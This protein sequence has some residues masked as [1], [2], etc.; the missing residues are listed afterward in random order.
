MYRRKDTLPWD[1]LGAALLSALALALTMQPPELVKFS[2]PLGIILVLFL[3]GYAVALAMFPRAGDLSAKERL[4]LSLGLCIAI[5]VLVAIGLSIMGGVEPVSLAQSLSAISLIT[6]AI[7]YVRRASLPRG[8]RFVPSYRRDLWPIGRRQTMGIQRNAGAILLALAVVIVLSAFAYT[9]TTNITTTITATPNRADDNGFT[10]FYV[11][12]E[13]SP[14]SVEAGSR[15]AL[16]VGIINRE[17]HAVDYTLRLALAHTLKDSILSEKNIELDHNETWEKPVS[18]IVSDPGDMQRL[19]LLLYKGSDFSKPYQEKHIWINVSGSASQS[20]L[21]DIS[22]SAAKPKDL[23]ESDLKDDGGSLSEDGLKASRND[24]STGGEAASKQSPQESSLEESK[25]EVLESQTPAPDAVPSPSAQEPSEQKVLPQPGPDTKENI[26]GE[27]ISLNY[28]KDIKVMN[29]SDV[30]QEIYEVEQKIESPNKQEN[31][32]NNIGMNINKI[33]NNS[34]SAIIKDINSSSGSPDSGLNRS[35]DRRLNGSEADISKKVRALEHNLTINTS[36]NNTPRAVQKFYTRPKPGSSI[37]KESA[38][39]AALKTSSSSEEEKSDT[40]SASDNSSVYRI[41]SETNASGR[42]AGISETGPEIEQATVLNKSN[43]TINVSS[44]A[45]IN[46]SIISIN[47]SSNSSKSASELRTNTPQIDEKLRM[48]EMDRKIDSW[49]RTRG[50]GT[51]NT[52]QSYESEI[53]Q[54]KG[55]NGSVVLGSQSKTPRRVG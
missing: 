18:Y 30:D 55:T 22:L 45:E 10:E 43:Q 9:Y 25:T 2:A 37:S 51:S 26:S 53:I 24:D 50:T 34:V 11:V 27:N 5:S 12:D 21:K 28:S 54:F 46:K 1:L 41:Q 20:D 44:S 49:V 7:A 47:D 15:S 40:K 42:D 17:H 29:A 38:A 6:I 33:L 52:S 39:S 35:H 48:A 3:P 19:D 16:I 23:H 31:N 8:W 14:I 32:I 36:S 13:S 4:L